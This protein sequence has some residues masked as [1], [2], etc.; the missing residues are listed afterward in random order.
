MTTGNNQFQAFEMATKLAGQGKKQEEIAVILNAQGFKT[1]MG[2][3][4]DNHSVSRM[5]RGGVR[6][7]KT[8]RRRRK[9]AA[10]ATPTR[11]KQD[12][13]ITLLEDIM[14]SNLSDL[15]KKKLVRLTASNLIIKGS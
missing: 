12:E 2:K 1:V 3:T 5:L 9:N 10:K 15:S 7:Y 8:H 13:S 6:K 4:F 11:S 14:S